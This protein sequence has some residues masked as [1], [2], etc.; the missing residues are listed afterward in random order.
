MT[1]QRNESSKNAQANSSS[2]QSS[3]QSAR[4]SSDSPLL[5]DDQLAAIH[6]LSQSAQA[7]KENRFATFKRLQSKAKRDYYRQE[8]MWPLIGI[9]LDIVLVVSL[10]VS[11]VRSKQKKVGL[12]I[13]SFSTMM[14]QQTGRKLQDQLNRIHVSNDPVRVETAYEYNGQGA[15]KLRVDASTNSIDAVIATPEVMKILAE[16]GFLT[17]LSRY[18][19]PQSLQFAV[20]YHG[21]HFASG[22]ETL[23]KAGKGSKR[24]YALQLAKSDHHQLNSLT[25][26]SGTHMQIAVF[27]GCPHPQA[28][29]KL[30][31]WAF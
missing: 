14:T 10:T 26:T 11:I 19:T 23:N 27:A 24:Y 15:V 4:P 22:K 31:A 12:Q 25:S 9:I 5:S 7:P 29:K 20:K 2:D 21:M 18:T 16:Q 13:V 8:F 6:D 1:Q 30:L 3:Q 17:D 28:V